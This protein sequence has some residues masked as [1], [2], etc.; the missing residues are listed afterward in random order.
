MASPAVAG[1]ATSVLLVSPESAEATALHHSDKRYRELELLL[2]DLAEAG[3]AEPDAGAELDGRRHINITWMAHDVNP[4][5]LDKIYPS[6][7]S[8]GLWIQMTVDPPSTKSRW[9]KAESPAALLR[10]LKSLGLMGPL[11]RDATSGMHP[12][13]VEDGSATQKELTSGAPNGESAATGKDGTH[14]APVSSTGPGLTENWWWAMPGL[15]AGALLA[16]LL[17]PLAPRLRTSASS[18]MPESMPFRRRPG[19]EGPRQEL[20]DL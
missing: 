17:R 12:E 3:R 7:G 2:P 16:L 8:T 15:V 5:R 13:T 20:R 10:L 9:H 19:E 4:W 11:S 18:R 1:G 6:S 14:I